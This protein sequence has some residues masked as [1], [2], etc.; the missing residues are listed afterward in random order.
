MSRTTTKLLAALATVP[1]LAGLAAC[2][3]PAAG[4]VSY[5]HLTLPTN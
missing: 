2:A 3:A 1:L 5:T 4:A